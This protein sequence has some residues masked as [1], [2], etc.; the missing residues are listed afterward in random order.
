[1]TNERLLIILSFGLWRPP[2]PIPTVEQLIEAEKTETRKSL[3]FHH[4][5]AEEHLFAVS[6]LEVRLTRLSGP[7]TV[8][9]Q[10]TK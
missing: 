1:M 6:M 5:M 7:R 10:V 2:P 8:L 9:H 4:R 3:L